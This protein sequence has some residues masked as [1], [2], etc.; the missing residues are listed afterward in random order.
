LSVSGG[1]SDTITGN[2]NTSDTAFSVNYTSRTFA[3]AFQLFR[4]QPGSL[5]IEVAIEQDDGAGGTSAYNTVVLAKSTGLRQLNG[6]YLIEVDQ[7]DVP[8]NLLNIN[9]IAK[10]V[11]VSLSYGE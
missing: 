1:I 7:L 10:N 11:R 8:S 4:D 2:I 6:L 5:D 9:N 3:F